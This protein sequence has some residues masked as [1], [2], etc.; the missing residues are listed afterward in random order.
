MAC[1]IWSVSH[2]LE[3]DTEQPATLDAD[4]I[5]LDFKTGVRIYRG[6]VVF[7]QGSIRI[8][9]NLLTTHF[10][11]DGELERAVCEGAPGTFRQ[12]PE[13][14]DQDVVGEAREIV[15]DQSDRLVT[16]KS[17]ARIMQGDSNMSGNLISYDLDSEK[18]IAKGGSVQSQET[19]EKNSGTGSQDESS[20]PRIVIQPRKPEG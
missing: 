12:R 18:A 8:T 1:L 20:R 14:E 6:N 16:M 17:G 9:C 4:E 5:E 7:S 13:G 19:D 2:A 11:D 3:N 10:D 15:L